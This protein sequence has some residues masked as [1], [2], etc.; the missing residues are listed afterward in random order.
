MIERIQAEKSMFF[1]RKKIS[2]FYAIYTSLLS[3]IYKS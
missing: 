1:A 2:H 3:F